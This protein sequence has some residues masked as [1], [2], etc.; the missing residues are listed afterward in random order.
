MSEDLGGSPWLV[1]DPARHTWL[2]LDPQDQYPKSCECRCHRKPTEPD[3]MHGW[4]LAG[5]L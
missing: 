4:H 1:F 3:E 5:E 2:C